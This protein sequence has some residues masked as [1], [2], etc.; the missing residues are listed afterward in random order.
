MSSCASIDPL[1]TPYVD[2]EIA[3][4]Q[5]ALVDA[6][7]QVCAPC[8]SR[9]EAERAVSTLLKARRQDLCGAAAPAGLRA[10]CRPSAADAAVLPFRPQDA[11]ARPTWRARLPRLAVAASLLLGLGGA[12]IYRVTVG[13]TQ[14]IA[15]ELTADHLKCFMLNGV[16]QNHDTE[17]E[18][19]RF[20]LDSFNWSTE[21]P[22]RHD[23]GDLELVGSRWCLYEHGRVAHVMYRH[24]GVPV[25]IFM[26]P[27]T[28]QERSLTYALGHDAVVWSEG[29]RTFV[30]IARAPRPEVEQVAAFVQRTLH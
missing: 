14:A 20:L 22:D 6:H 9:I 1:V 21:L 7:V 10:R 30:L 17:E 24:K 13:A 18:A 2:G 4:D 26:L 28:T 15:A 5:R 8:R 19:E 11:P 23:D 16:L 25:S 3:G 29:T 12:A 27:D